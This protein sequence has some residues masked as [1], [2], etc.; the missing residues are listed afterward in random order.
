MDKIII[1]GIDG[2]SFNILDKW[3]KKGSLPTFKKLKQKGSY[4]KLTSTIP[5]VTPPAWT[6][7]T[8][9]KNPGKHDIFDFQKIDSEHKFSLINSTTN[10]AK[11]FWEYTNKK[12]ILINF[13][14]YFPPKKI[15]GYMVSGML[16]PGISSNFTY[17]KELKKEILNI[18]PDYII[19]VDENL[20]KGRIKEFLSDIDKMTKQRHKLIKH[21][22]KKEWDIFFTVI[23][24]SDR[25]QHLAW[26]NQ[27]LLNYYKKVDSILDDIIKN[28]VKDN[29]T[30]F[31]ISDHGF[32]E[33]N[34]IF[35]VNTF[36]KQEQILFTKEKTNK[37]ILKKV[38]LTRETIIN[39][40]QKLHIDLTKLKILL[41]NKI[42][43][44][45]PQE[46]QTLYQSVNWSKTK[47]FMFGFGQIFIN[48]KK[49]FKNAPLSEKQHNKFK[50]ELIKILSNIKDPQ[51]NK[52]IIKK[53]YTNEQ[54]YSGDYAKNGP[55]LIIELENGYAF[56]EKITNQ[57]IEKS[58]F[59]NADHEKQGILMSY[60]KQIKENNNMSNKNIVDFAP[61]ML[62]I[63]NS[64]IPND[65]DGKVIKDI[66]KKDS[67]LCKK[68]AKI[69]KITEKENISTALSDIN[70]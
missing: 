44:L 10:K 66:F 5:P 15:N 48:S 11:D 54:A 20:Y 13:P 12:T 60:G 16:T 28:H 58:D 55:D 33:V 3:I 47:A 25:I 43:N 6:S 24:G 69:K 40:L 64:T 45:L 62:H 39:L 21:M 37:K 7:I 50:K 29:V 23:T 31:I 9:G 8:T 26:N 14:T 19:E 57:H 1:I 52:K 42:K 22:L 4:C 67:E 59:I 34:K 27:N 65:I 51:T 41:P 46:D 35:Y 53:V 49:R 36:L 32:T 63:L 18:I 61:T 56:S 38:G 68:S 70:I 17:P 30:L 2:A